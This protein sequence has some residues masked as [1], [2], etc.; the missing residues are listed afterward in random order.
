M[1]KGRA[2]TFLDSIGKRNDILFEGLDNFSLKVHGDVYIYLDDLCFLF[3]K[4]HKRE[5][6]F[7]LSYSFG[8]GG[9]AVGGRKVH[10]LLYHE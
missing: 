5:G 1:A 8:C 7:F 3:T 10:L 6:V 9:G 2:H 4:H